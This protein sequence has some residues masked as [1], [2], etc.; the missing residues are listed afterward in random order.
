MAGA[1]RVTGDKELMRKL[2]LLPE[3]IMRK[4]MRK[5]VTRA[6]QIVLKRARA[7]AP[8]AK[9]TYKKALA[10]KTKT[11]KK[12]NSVVGIIGAKHAAAPHQ[13]L[14][15]EGTKERFRRS[16]GSTGRM[17]ASHHMAKVL[18]DT[19]RLVLSEF[20][21]KLGKEIEREAAKL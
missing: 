4:V 15:E 10:K 17:P 3:R 16:G 19:S 9:G 12:T 14:I 20:N 2:H 1:I 11:Y 18:R 8:V 21:I 5:A 13:Y 7:T 6:G